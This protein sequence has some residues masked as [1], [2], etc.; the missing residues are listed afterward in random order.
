MNKTGMT[1]QEYSQ[2]VDEK[3]PNTNWLKNL[4]WAFV[5]GGLI[6]DIGQI[7]NNFYASKGMN[8]EQTGGATA[9]TM[10]FLGALATGLNVYDKLARNAGAGTIVPITGFAN[11][12]V[13]PAM[14][15]KSEGFVL[16]VGAKMFAIAGPVLV[17]GTVASVIAGFVYYRNRSRLSKVL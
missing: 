9:I 13:D 10:I 16:G 3:S 4:I 11:A 5:V 1:K 8:A 15:H 2:Y 6:C 17:Y 12:V 14:E 7:F